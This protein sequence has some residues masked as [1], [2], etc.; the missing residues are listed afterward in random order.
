MVI[1]RIYWVKQIVLLEL[2]LPVFIFNVA[3]RKC[4]MARAAHTRL[5]LHFYWAVPAGNDP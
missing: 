1:F 3:T 2:I 5:A 4:I